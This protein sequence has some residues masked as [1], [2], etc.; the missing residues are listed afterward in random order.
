MGRGLE[1]SGP[2]SLGAHARAVAPRL[3]PAMKAGQDGT[4]T[5]KGYDTVGKTTVAWDLKL[6]S[7]V[8][9]MK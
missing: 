4:V 9:A 2:D 1:I 6:K 5:R 7:K 3:G 8:H